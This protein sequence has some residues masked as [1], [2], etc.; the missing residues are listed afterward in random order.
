MARLGKQLRPRVTASIRDLAKSPNFRQNFDKMLPPISVPWPQPVD[1][2]VK[3]WA[4][5]R[6]A[7]DRCLSHTNM[8]HTKA[9]NMSRI[10]SYLSLTLKC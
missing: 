4:E 5:N 1:L 7:K 10:F 6:F 3:S 8:T 9:L 2:L